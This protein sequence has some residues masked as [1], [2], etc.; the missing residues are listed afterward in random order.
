[1]TFS[2]LLGAPN[3][4]SRY[5]VATPNAVTVL[6]LILRLFIPSRRVIDVWMLLG[7]KPPNLSLNRFWGLSWQDSLSIKNR[8]DA[9][10][11]TRTI[12]L[13]FTPWCRNSAETIAHAKANHGRN[14]RGMRDSK[15]KA[16]GSAKRAEPDGSCLT[17]H[18]QTN[19]TK[20]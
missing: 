18:S 20:S 6:Y 9:I 17:K 2:Y 13:L 1:M 8:G 4:L 14:T 12:N 15:E 5:L 10:Q 7:V 11:R 19:I 3:I 16:L